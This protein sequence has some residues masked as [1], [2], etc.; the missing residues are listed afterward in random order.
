MPLPASRAHARNAGRTRERLLQAAFLEIYKSGF[1][2][3]DL[4]TLLAHAG[5]TKGAMYHHFA[6]KEALGYA[7]VED[8]LGPITQQKWLQPLQQHDANPI[9]VLIAIVQGTSLRPEHV[10]LGCPLNNLSQE[11]APLDEGFRRRTAQIFADWHGGISAA[12]ERGQ[13]RGQVAAV[14]NAAESAHFLIALYEG[15][16]SLA[17]NAQHAGLLKSGQ[18]GIVAYLESLRSA[19]VGHA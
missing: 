19:P 14:V 9:D 16:Q 18:R 12:L 6:S 4:K 5:V 2:G 8:V 17:K 11:M 3:T 1:R 15:F 13:H 10:R 7:V